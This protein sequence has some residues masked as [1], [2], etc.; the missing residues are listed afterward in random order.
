MAKERKVRELPLPR[1]EDTLLLVDI[2]PLVLDTLLLAVDTLRPEVLILP[3][4]DTLPLVDILVN[5]VCCYSFII[6][7]FILLNIN[8]FFKLKK[9]KNYFFIF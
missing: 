3:K 4:V 7:L 9:I 5:L 2:L 1:P 8:I 6:S